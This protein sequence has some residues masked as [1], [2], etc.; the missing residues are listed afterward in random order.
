MQLTQTEG[1]LTAPAMSTGFHP[2]RHVN[3]STAIWCYRMQPRCRRL[4][5]GKATTWSFA[6][7]QT[8]SYR[9]HSVLLGIGSQMAAQTPLFSSL[10]R[11]LSNAHMQAT[12]QTVLISSKSSSSWRGA[13]VPAILQTPTPVTMQHKKQL[14]QMM[15]RSQW[16]QL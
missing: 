14:T 11:P 9:Q 16:Q 5:S 2:A 8:R 4:S 15:S 12:A 13:L 3:A 1:H 6:L 10:M 7:D